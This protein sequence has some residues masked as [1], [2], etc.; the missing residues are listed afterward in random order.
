[1]KVDTKYSVYMYVSIR[2]YVC[3]YTQGIVHICIQVNAKYSVY[4]YVSI[5]KHVCVNIL[6]V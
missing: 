5:R 4:M 6:K 1:M 2:Q 3:K